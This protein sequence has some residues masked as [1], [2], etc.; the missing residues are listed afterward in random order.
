V[1]FEYQPQR[2]HEVRELCFF[3][4]SPFFLFLT[5]FA[6][7]FAATCSKFYPLAWSSIDALATGVRIEKLGN[8]STV[9]Y[10][11]G[12][13]WAT[14]CAFIASPNRAHSLSSLR[15]LV[16]RLSGLNNVELIDLPSVPVKF[17]V[18][19]KVTIRTDI[20][21]EPNTLP[22]AP[23]VR[24]LRALPSLEAIKCSAA[25]VP[26]I[27]S[28]LPNLRKLN[29][30]HA[31]RCIVKNPQWPKLE[32]L[33]CIEY[34]Q[35]KVNLETLT[36]LRQLDI[37]MAWIHPGATDSDLLPLDG[38]LA[39]LPNLALIRIPSKLFGANEGMP[40]SF[41]RVLSQFSGLFS[42]KFRRLIANSCMREPYGSLLG[43]VLW[44]SHT[45]HD[46]ISQR[47]LSQQLFESP[48]FSIAPFVQSSV[49][50][51]SK[52]LQRGSLSTMVID[53]AGKYN[54]RLL[55]EALLYHAGVLKPVFAAHDYD[56]FA[57][58]VLVAEDY[59]SRIDKSVGILGFDPLYNSDPR[60]CCPM[61]RAMLARLRSENGQEI[62]R[63]IRAY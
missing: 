55:F 58:C 36:N 14:F 45:N 25:F 39:Q 19:R 22:A 21:A 49:Q 37:E 59:F 46:D 30:F 28:S 48:Y 13:D 4:F 52:W 61:I 42:S 20:V 35:S 60:E 56:H 41:V 44:M 31:A 6:E 38:I 15:S 9:Q 12:I 29:I 26:H 10:E 62:L 8:W 50:S 43:A 5:I 18:L 34:I 57:L 16:V 23:V 3:L 54:T 53:N 32:Q 27:E 1:V 11:R 33:K 63:Q 51:A 24:F 2:F 7:R 17:P 40:S 47:Y